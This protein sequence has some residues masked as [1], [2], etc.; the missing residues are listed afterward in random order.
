[1]KIIDSTEWMVGGRR[2]LN[3]QI[4]E[5]EPLF[6]LTRDSIAFEVRYLLSF[7]FSELSCL[8]KCISVVLLPL[9]FRISS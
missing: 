5:V 7:Q 3:N 9:A 8:S 4:K 6:A 2:N 1:M